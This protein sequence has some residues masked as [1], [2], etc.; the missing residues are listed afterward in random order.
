MPTREY[1]PE[2]SVTLLRQIEVEMAN[3]RDT[4]DQNLPQSGRLLYSVIS[5][6][7]NIILP[8]TKAKSITS[9]SREWHAQKP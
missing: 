8:G 3:G 2:Q 4:S 7:R 1:K 9:W 5:G 6:F